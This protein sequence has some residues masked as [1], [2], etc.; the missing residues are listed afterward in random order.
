MKKTYFQPK[1]IIEFALCETMLA[2]SLFDANSDTQNI[3]P[4]NEEYN[5]EFAVKEYSFGDDLSE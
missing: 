1:T 2:A 5:G 3:T 4:S